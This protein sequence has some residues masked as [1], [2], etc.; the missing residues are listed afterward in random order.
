MKTGKHAHGTEPKDVHP[1]K[2]Q[3]KVGRIWGGHAKGGAVEEEA[4]ERMCGGKAA[5]GKAGKAEG[6]KVGKAE[7]GRA[8]RASGG[9]VCESNP[10]SSAHART[11]APGR[12][13]QQGNAQ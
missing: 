11:P 1:I 2:T 6:G 7:G 10:F 13:L 8:S 5:G 12:K 9:A 4:K 3:K